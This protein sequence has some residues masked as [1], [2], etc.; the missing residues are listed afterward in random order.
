M[1]KKITIKRFRDGNPRDIA[2]ELG[3]HYAGDMNAIPHDGTFYETANWEKHGYANCVRIVS[4]ENTL[5][6]ECGT[7]NKSDDVDAI[8]RS[9]G[10]ELEDGVVVCPHSGDEVGELTAELLIE[11]T[12]GYWGCDVG[13]SQTFSENAAGEF[14]EWKIWQY[15]RPHILNLATGAARERHR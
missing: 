7:I 6:V 1:R 5:W 4:A 2:Q 15:A 11:A 8:L 14:P 13:D 10:W 12:R 9:C 3:I